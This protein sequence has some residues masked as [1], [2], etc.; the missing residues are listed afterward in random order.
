VRLGPRE[1]ECAARLHYAHAVRVLFP[2]FP[3]VFYASSAARVSSGDVDAASMIQ[4]DKGVLSNVFLCFSSPPPLSPR[5]CRWPRG[6]PPPP[7]FRFFMQ[8]AS[9]GEQRFCL[10][11]PSCL[12]SWFQSHPPPTSSGHPFP[13]RIFFLFRSLKKKLFFSVAVARGFVLVRSPPASLQSGAPEG[14]GNSRTAFRKN[15]GR[16]GL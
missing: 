12:D 10:G 9:P 8:M 14:R 11:F 13:V 3:P 7:R 5:P 15:G 6:I 4:W 2:S 1:S 16:P